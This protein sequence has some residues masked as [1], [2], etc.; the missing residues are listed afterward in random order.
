[1][2]IIRAKIAYIM[3]IE[4]IYLTLSNQLYESLNIRSVFNGK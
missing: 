3:K 2:L 4:S 1:M